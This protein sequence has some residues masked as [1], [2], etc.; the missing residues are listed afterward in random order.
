VSAGAES[1]GIQ[2]RVLLG[3]LIGA[4]VGFVIGYFGRCTSGACPLTGNPY[5][6]TVFGALMG[7]LVAAGK[8]A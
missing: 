1:K 4:A 3:I 2:M 6:S 8:N 7:G 5:I